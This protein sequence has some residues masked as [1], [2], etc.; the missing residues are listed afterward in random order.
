[1]NATDSL[2]IR[3]SKGVSLPQE[4]STGSLMKGST[5]VVPRPVSTSVKQRPRS[6]SSTY[7]RKELQEAGWSALSGTSN[8]N[9]TRSMQC[10]DK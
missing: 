1:M 5:E 3:R 8:L 4:H 2:M 9:S 7:L 10:S 6:I